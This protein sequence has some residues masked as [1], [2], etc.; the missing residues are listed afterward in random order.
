MA[1]T[2]CYVI[3]PKNLTNKR[4]SYV[5]LSFKIFDNTLSSVLLNTIFVFIKPFEYVHTF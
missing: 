5:L 4:Y 2:D 1:E 3:A